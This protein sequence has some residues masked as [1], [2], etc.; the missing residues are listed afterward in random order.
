MCL[1][2]RTAR[3]P[4]RGRHHNAMIKLLVEVLRRIAPLRDAGLVGAELV[5]HAR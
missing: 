3:D 1:V 4:L 5:I 2:T